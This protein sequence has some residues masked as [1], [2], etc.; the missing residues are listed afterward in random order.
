MQNYQTT[1]G[2]NGRI[3]IPSAFRKALGIKKGDRL[4]VRLEDGEVRVYSYEQALRRTQEELRQYVPEGELLSERL[5][6]ERRAE[7]ERE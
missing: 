7:A 3:V 4:L 2:E 6:A 1:V 5:I